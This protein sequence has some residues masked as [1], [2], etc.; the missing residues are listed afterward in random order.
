MGPTEL[1]CAAGRVMDSNERGSTAV[2][3]ERRANPSF[4]DDASCIE[5]PPG[6]VLKHGPR[7]LSCAQANGSVATSACVPVRYTQRRR[8]LELRDYGFGTGASLRRTPPSQGV[9]IRRVL[10]HPAGI[11]GVR[12]MRPERW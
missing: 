1:W 3:S 11:P 4:G 7:S 2:F 10:A 9:P 5:A 6:P 12:R 8:Q